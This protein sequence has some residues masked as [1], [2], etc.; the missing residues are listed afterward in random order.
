MTCS[1]EDYGE[2][3]KPHLFEQYKLY[4][5]MADK[6]SERRQSANSFFLTINTVIVSLTAYFTSCGISCKSIIL[7]SP[8]SIAGLVICFMWYRLIRSY[9]DLNT[10]KFKVIH[11]IEQKLPCAP[12]DLE[13]EKVGR[14]KNSKLYLPF[15]HIEIC[16]PWVFLALHV[17]VLII[18]ILKTVDICRVI[19]ILR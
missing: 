12:Y 17:F 4:V 16:V 1:Q 14:G 9:K 6:I 15:T 7:F 2:N 18:I 8:I 11:E 13:W 3:Y 5:E 19:E 10:A